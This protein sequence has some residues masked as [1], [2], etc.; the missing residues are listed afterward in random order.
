[1]RVVHNPTAVNAYNNLS[2][3]SRALNSNLER[4]SSG[5]RINRAADDAAGLSIAQRE[6]AAVRGLDQASRNIQDGISV[7]QT[8][9]AG[10]D[11][12]HEMLQRMRE[13][14]VQASNG[15]LQSSDRQAIQSEM[16]QLL[17][18]VN[19]QADATEFNGFKLLT[20]NVSST[21]PTQ[22][23]SSTVSNDEVGVGSAT[24]NVYAKFSAAGFATTP[25]GNITVNGAKFSV[26]DYD[27]VNAFMQAINKSEEANATISY[28][29]T[30]DRFTI[31]SDTEEATLRLTQ[32]SAA[33]TA[34]NGFL[35]Q[36]RITTALKLNTAAPGPRAQAISREEIAAGTDQILDLT[37]SF[38]TAGFDT[39]P[40]GTIAINGVEFSVADYASVQSF[41]DAINASDKA[42]ATISYDAT[43]DEF[44][45]QS[46]NGTDLTLSAVGGNA[47]N[48]LFEANILDRYTTTA[49]TT[50]Y[51]NIF[52]APSANA[53]AISTYE[54]NPATDEDKDRIDLTK[55]FDQAHFHNQPTGTIS[56]NGETFSVTGTVQSF[57]D[58]VN[59]NSNI[60]VTMYYDTLEDKFAIRSDDLQKDL[61]LSETPSTNGFGFLSETN[62]TEGTYTPTSA[63]NS[64]YRREGL[65]F[66]A[67]ANKDER[68]KTNI[69]TVSTS[70]LAIDVLKTNGVATQDAANSAIALLDTAIDKLSKNRSDLGALQNR[71]EHH[72]SY[73]ETSYENH[74]AA[75]SRIEDLDFAKETINF[76]KNQILLN[77]G[78]SM[79]AQA[80]M[81]PANVLSLLAT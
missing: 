62:I 55:G 69:A 46:D 49:N 40:T 18:S 27:S 56:I 8:A 2:Q 73:N 71:M 20:G 16:D 11:E 39:T 48:F 38:A 34:A 76:V 35:T 23:K 74:T 80:N 7:V 10:M 33:G 57:M 9:E 28:D 41:M 77:S 63:V 45:I 3:T 21:A 30:T 70:A 47:T 67:G 26:S 65:V 24:I 25:T 60:D 59:N 75:L 37:K 78:T 17:D 15:S 58:N 19:Q 32:S 42:K 14:S 81:A 52:R 6:T 13:L 72:L 5:L 66:H 53:T 68:V 64:D 22:Y 43:N 44:L 31:T 79:L 36:A 54:V 4:L 51:S 50:T 61:T 1:M 12:I 29:V